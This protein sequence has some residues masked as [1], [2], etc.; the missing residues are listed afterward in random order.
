MSTTTQ[1]L[2]YIKNRLQADTIKNLKIFISSTDTIFLV[3]PQTL[4]W[5]PK[6]V[7]KIFK[8]CYQHIPITKSSST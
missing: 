3:P 2:K 1:F 7:R 5:A 8:E 4:K 6:K